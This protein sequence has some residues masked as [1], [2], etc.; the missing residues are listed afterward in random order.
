MLMWFMHLCTHETPHPLAQHPTVS[1]GCSSRRSPRVR[2]RG[3]ARR[4]TSCGRASARDM[5]TATRSIMAVALSPV[6][7]EPWMCQ[8]PMCKNR[9]GRRSTS[10]GRSPTASDQ[11]MRSAG[12]RSNKQ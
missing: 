5:A 3:L 2:S 1:S 4:R 10:A 6:L 12:C 9:Y 11:G 8:D 7:A